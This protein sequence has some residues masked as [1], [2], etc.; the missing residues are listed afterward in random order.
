M[1]ITPDMSDSAIEPDKSAIKVNWAPGP[2]WLLRRD[3][4]LRCLSEVPRGKL[5]EV[6]CG[7]GA[8]L[9]EYA[10]LGFECQALETS[11]VAADAARQRASQ[12]DGVYVRDVPGDNWS[13]HFDYVVA[14][15]VLE[16]I[17]RDREA[18][19]EWCDW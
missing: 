11:S 19:T 17:E 14:F 12:I 6:G 10:R 13:S 8:M 1:P 15:E 2:T 3:R 16:H 9:G 7:A 4:I 5:L 18:V